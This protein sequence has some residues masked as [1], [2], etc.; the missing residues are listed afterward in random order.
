MASY[1]AA[2]WLLFSTH[3]SEHKIINADDEVGRRWLG[4]LTQ[5]VA[6]SM[7]GNILWIWNDHLFICHSESSLSTIMVPA[8]LL[9]S[10]GRNS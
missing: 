9:I 3:H 7:E 6:V 1:E 5:A 2:K 4:P 8:L 10:W